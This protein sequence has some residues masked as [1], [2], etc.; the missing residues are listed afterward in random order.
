MAAHASRHMTGSGQ[1]SLAGSDHYT[2]QTRK[3]ARN[4]LILE[5]HRVTKAMIKKPYTLMILDNNMPIPC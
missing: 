4:Q 2:D 3:S 1:G 5:F